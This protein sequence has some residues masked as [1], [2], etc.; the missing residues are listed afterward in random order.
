MKNDIDSLKKIYEDIETS[1]RLD[2]VINNAIL[3]GKI[4]M[5]KSNRKKGILKSIVGIAAAVGIFT[6]SIN[7]IPSFA[8]KLEDV[9]VLGSLVKVLQFNEGKSQGG[10][11]TDGVN[12]NKMFLQKG[13][14]SDSILISFDSEHIE[15]TTPYFDVKYKEAPYTM[16]F[17]VSGVRDFTARKYFDEI[18][19][20]QYV[21]DIYSVI[22]LDDSQQRFNIVFNCP[23]TFEIE[24]Y[25]NPSSIKVT[26]SE[27]T[28]KDSSHKIY[29]VRTNSYEK[30]EEFAMM[31]EILFEIDT[32]RVLKDKN[33]TFLYELGNYETE[34]EAIE[35]MEELKNTYG[36]SV[37]LLVEERT[38]EGLP[39]AN[40][41]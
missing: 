30:G 35:K 31:E 5:K 16:T 1:D 10:E 2:E 21:K 41:K 24:E 27:D 20:S 14:D 17:S 6:V 34:Q 36:E 39:S 19:S 38:M 15:D 8:S 9:P 29:S 23:V 32:L 13:K 40:S 18:R 11:I 3:R 33:R 4:D 22:T 28:S 12:I 37:K 7:G 25:K 26:I